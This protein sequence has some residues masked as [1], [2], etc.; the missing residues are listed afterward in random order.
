MYNENRI[1]RLLDYKNLLN[2]LKT[3]GFI[4]VFSDNIADA[5]GISSS[6]VRKDFSIFG[7]AGSQKGGYEIDSVLLKIDRILGRDEVQKIIVVGV[8]RIGEALMYYKAFPQEGLQVVA[9]FDIDPSKI[10]E[11][12]EIPVY[13][14]NKLPEYVTRYDI[15]FAIL[16]VPE[17]A[18]QQ[19]IEL[20][21]KQRIQGI[22][23]FTA[24][25]VKDSME[26]T[27]V[28]INIL[29]ELSRLIY[30]VNND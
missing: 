21:K 5:L 16:A 9:G 24:L 10:D 15:R 29:H 1:N 18:A 27:I 12:A 28:H 26:T 3:L 25:N 8:G 30:L 14:I 17:I 23:N 19:T 20:L 7:I 13:S 11:Q 2:Q 4:K 22:L 6:L